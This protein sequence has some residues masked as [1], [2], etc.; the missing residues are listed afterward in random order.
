MTLVDTETAVAEALS[1]G[2]S[3]YIAGFGH[4]I[5]HAIGHEIIRQGPRDLAVTR[6]VLANLFDQL[7][8]AG[9][10]STVATSY[11]AGP[12]FDRAWTEGI[13]TAVE[14]EEYTHF[15]T[16]A[17]VHAGARNMPFVPVRTFAGSDLVEKNDKIRYVESPYDGERVPV[18]PPLF[19]DVTILHAQRA[20]EDGN[21]QIW[22]LETDVRD[23]AFAADT[24][25]ASVEEV[26]APETIRRDPNRTV[27]PAS[28]VDYVT[29]EPFGAHPGYV[30]GYYGNDRSYSDYRERAVTREGAEAWLDEWV[31]GLADRAEYVEKVGMD[32]LR[33]LA[34][35]ERP[36]G[37]VDLGRYA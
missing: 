18:L 33:S 15:G 22:G 25:I 8:A 7:I 24:V 17:L 23:A 14:L 4:L 3:L 27:V 11:T 37:S 30:Q 13:P 2:D 16:V 12:S 10:V 5:P 26:V 1:D 32:H 21:V 36:T 6:P 19:P 20:D 34:P 29:E 35:A 28:E 9:C 31:Y